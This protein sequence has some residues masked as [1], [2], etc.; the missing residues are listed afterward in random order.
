MLHLYKKRMEEDTILKTRIKTVLPILNEH[1]RRIYLDAEAKSIGWGGVSK[2]SELTGISRRTIAKGGEKEFEKKYNSKE[3]IRKSGGG[4]KAAIELHP[5]LLQAIE[6][7]VS[8]HTMG[9]PMNPLIWTS[10]SIR[11]IQQ[12]LIP[13]GYSISHELVRKC[14]LALIYSLHAN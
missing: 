1:Q 11:K 4:R 7:I 14:L 9:D 8:P 12:S 13:L 10:K 3:G 2:I 5:N 6:T